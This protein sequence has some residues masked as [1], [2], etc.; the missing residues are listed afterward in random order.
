MSQETI[1]DLS[2]WIP[3]MFYRFR[4]TNVIR[5]NIRRKQLDF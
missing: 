3:A 2:G 1:A 4:E 5:E